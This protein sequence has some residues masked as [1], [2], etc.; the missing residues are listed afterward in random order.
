MLKVHT[1]NSAL[2]ETLKTLVTHH[3]LIKSCPMIIIYLVTRPKKRRLVSFVA[4]LP[5]FVCSY[6]GRFLLLQR[7]IAYSGLHPGIE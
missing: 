6:A 2:V 3:T 7:T 4:K 1:S 5:N